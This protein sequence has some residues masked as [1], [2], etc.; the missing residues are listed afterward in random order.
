MLDMCAITYYPQ[1]VLYIFRE[2]H[3]FLL[4]SC[5]QSNENWGG[6]IKHP[7]SDNLMQMIAPSVMTRNPL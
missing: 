2:R 3:V 7:H 6:G 1:Y 5:M 4:V